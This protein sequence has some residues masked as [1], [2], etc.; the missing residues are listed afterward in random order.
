MAIEKEKELEEADEGGI[1]PVMEDAKAFSKILSDIGCVPPCRRKS[2]GRFGQEEE[3]GTRVL[4]IPDST[5]EGGKERN[6]NGNGPGWRGSVVECRPMN[7]EVTSKDAPVTFTVDG[8]VVML[9][10]GVGKMDIYTQQREE[11]GMTKRTTVQ[12]KE[13]RRKAKVSP[14]HQTTSINPRALR[15]ETLSEHS[16]EVRQQPLASHTLYLQ[17]SH[18]FRSRPLHPQRDRF[19]VISSSPQGDCFQV[20]ATSPQGDCSSLLPAQGD[21]S[22]SWHQPQGDRFQV[23]ATSPQGDCFQVMATSPQGDCFQYGTTWL[24][25]RWLQPSG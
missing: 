23:M 15:G 2:H 13:R 22:R 12:G 4:S 21:D 18:G 3:L 24:T 25:L 8:A 10:L 5:A 1:A 14:R 6:K 7:Q 11:V 20:M 16:R 19:Q 9:G 17:H